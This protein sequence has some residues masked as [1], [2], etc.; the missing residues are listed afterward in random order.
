MKQPPSTKPRK[1]RRRFP[2]FRKRVE[3]DEDKKRFE[4]KL[5]SWRR[6]ISFSQEPPETVFKRSL[7]PPEAVQKAFG[8]SRV[9]P[10][11]LHFRYEAFL[12]GDD[13]LAPFNVVARSLDLRIVHRPPSP[14]EGRPKGQVSTVS[15]S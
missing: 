10:L 4:A 15:Y 1:N 7:R 9:L 13:A 3:C 12:G 11:G 6:L 14:F 2:V 5:A 8:D